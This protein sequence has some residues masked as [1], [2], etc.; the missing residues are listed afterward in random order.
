[1][2]G[3]EAKTQKM[4][5]KPRRK[6][7]KRLTEPLIAFSALQ[8][9]LSGKNFTI[10]MQ[11]LGTSKY[12]IAK[13]TGI[14]WKTLRNWEKGST[15]PSREAGI[16]VGTYL[17]IITPRDIRKIELLEELKILERKIRALEG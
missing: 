4:K 14:T 10:L 15:L 6:E 3:Q 16:K 1:M 17:G 11:R 13:E 12:K 2:G 7:E 9:Q 8:A 5:G